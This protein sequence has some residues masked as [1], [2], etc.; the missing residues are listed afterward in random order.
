MLRNMI[1]TMA[2]GAMLGVIVIGAKKLWE[3]QHVQPMKEPLVGR[4]YNDTATTC[5]DTPALTV[6]TASLDAETI[7]DIDHEESP[8]LTKPLR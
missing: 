5:A 3:R 6:E 1:G 8:A 2:K 7:I 4:H